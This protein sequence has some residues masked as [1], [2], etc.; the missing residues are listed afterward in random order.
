MVHY[1]EAELDQAEEKHQEAKERKYRKQ[2]RRQAKKLGVS[3]E[4]L[5]SCQFWIQEGRA[6][7]E[8]EFT[9]WARNQHKRACKKYEAAYPMNY[10]NGKCIHM[11]H[12]KKP[13][14]SF[15]SNTGICE[16]GYFVPERMHLHLL[17]TFNKRARKALREVRKQLS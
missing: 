9:W 13:C 11:V 8:E 15:F 5:E 3:V 4:Y 1:T 10:Y 7:T 16:T 2:L 17:T 6:P 12:F 14:V